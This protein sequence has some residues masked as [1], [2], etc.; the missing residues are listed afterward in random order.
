MPLPEPIP[1][2]KCANVIEDS[3][4][5]VASNMTDYD[6]I[7]FPGGGINSLKITYLL[8]QRLDTGKPTRF[9]FNAIGIHPERH[10][11]ELSDNIERILNDERVRQITTR[12][13]LAMT[14]EYVTSKKAYPIQLI[15]DPAICSSE[16]YRI[17]RQ[18]DSETIGIGPIRP[19]IFEEQGTSMT[20]DDVYDMYGQLFKEVEARGYSWKVFC[21]GTQRDFDF[22]QEVLERFGYDLESHLVRKPGKAIDLVRDIAAFKGVIAAR[23]HA[24]IIST[25]L[26]I[27]SVAL[28]WNVKMRSFADLIGC[29]H[30]YIEEADKLLDSTYLVDS[31]EKA[32]SEGYDRQR[33]LDA[34]NAA[35]L[36]LKNVVLDGNQY[37]WYFKLMNRIQKESFFR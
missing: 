26:G 34:K 33:I 32:I 19:D 24:N 2:V 25:S 37:E 6:K 13:D 23:F 36:T 21:N 10:Y 16:A 30:R 14:Q 20:V 27:P 1:Y 18:E 17:K 29:R 5:R 31:L 7:V 3:E 15:T 8:L 4:E 28:V 12:G 9:Y 11:P 35:Y 22:A